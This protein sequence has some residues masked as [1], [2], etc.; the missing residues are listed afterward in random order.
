MWIKVLPNG[1]A[2]PQFDPVTGEDQQCGDYTGPV[3]QILFYPIT[4][5]LAELINAQGDVAEASDLKP[6][7]FDVPPGTPVEF[8]RT[9]TLRIDPQNICGFC[10][11]EFEYSSDMCPRCLAKNQWYC[12]ACDE[13][14]ADPIVDLSNDQIRCPTCEV[15]DPRGV[16]Q[17]QCIGESCSE[18]LFTHYV[19][20]IGDK[21]HLILDYKLARP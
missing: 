13:L 8:Y 10:E 1:H 6:L 19:L 11:L 21:R 12:G 15:I 17:I 20:I 7:C 16:R 5:R 3:A 14:V 18:R 2:L 9:G 4:P